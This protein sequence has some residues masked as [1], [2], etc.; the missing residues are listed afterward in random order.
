M[1]NIF[2]QGKLIIYFIIKC[3]NTLLTR[4]ISVET[5]Q[6]DFSKMESIH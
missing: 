2:T 4:I 5:S 1:N 3:N 6:S